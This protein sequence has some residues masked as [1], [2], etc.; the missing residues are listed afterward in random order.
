MP[1]TV[2]D[3]LNG[4][5]TDLTEHLNL[6]KNE[7]VNCDP[8]D[9]KAKYLE[10]EVERLQ[11]RL[12]FLVGQRDEVQASGKTRY[13]YKFGTIEY[14]R[15]GFEDVTDIN[16]MFVYYTRRI[17]EVNEAPSKKVKCME[18]LMKVYEELKG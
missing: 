4:L 5:V 15:Q 9:P 16:H 18:N 12:D 2:L 14:F 17:L 11:E 13:V 3:Q 1:I 6:T 10:K 7:L 8:G